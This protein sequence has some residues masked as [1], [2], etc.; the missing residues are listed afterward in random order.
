MKGVQW[1]G[2]GIYLICI[3]DRNGRVIAK[4]HV[5]CAVKT[6]MYSELDEFAAEHP[7][8]ERATVWSYLLKGAE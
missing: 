1:H 3:G 8:L 4:R 2:P 7:E 5:S 6:D